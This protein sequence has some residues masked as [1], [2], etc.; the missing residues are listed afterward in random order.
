MNQVDEDLQ[1]F[2]LV[3]RELRHIRVLTDDGDSVAGQ[4]GAIQ[5]QRIVHELGDG[6]L[7]PEARDPRI[8]LLHGHDFFDVLHIAGKLIMFRQRAACSLS[9]RRTVG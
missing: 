6:N 9:S 3:H 2:V 5:L 7:F 1:D 8:I 4:A